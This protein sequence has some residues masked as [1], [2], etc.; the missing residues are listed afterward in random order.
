MLMMNNGRLHDSP[1]YADKDQY[2]SEAGHRH[3][4]LLFQPDFEPDFEPEYEPEY[5]PLL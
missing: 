1:E 2:V 4:T 3:P 5:E